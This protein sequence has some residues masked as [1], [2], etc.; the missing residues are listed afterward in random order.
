VK[1]RKIDNHSKTG[2]SS[3]FNVSTT[4]EI[5]VSYHNGDRKSQSVDDW[6]VMLPNG[7]W[8][9]LKDAFRDK[10]IIPDDIKLYFRPP[11]TEAE[12]ERGYYYG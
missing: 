5:I 9:I 3:S 8:K 1:V 10:D 2:F 4:E 12:R 7:D 11:I 6:E